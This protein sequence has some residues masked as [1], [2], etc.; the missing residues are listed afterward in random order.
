MY[1]I[2][3]YRLFF[4][5][6]TERDC[7]KLHIHEISLSGRQTGAKYYDVSGKHAVKM[8]LTSDSTVT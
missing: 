2:N 8:R 6:Q 4:M 7:D 3:F 5:L 1:H